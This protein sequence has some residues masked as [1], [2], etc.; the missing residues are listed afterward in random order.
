MA[1]QL[2]GPEAIRAARETWRRGQIVE[3]ATRLMEKQGFHQMSVAALADEAGISV[4]TIYQYVQRKEDVLL[5]VILDILDAYREEMPAVM[6]GIADPIERLAAGFRAYCGV[7]DRR[8]SATVLTYRESKAL[9]ED[10]LHKIMQLELETT[11][12][13]AACLREARAAGIVAD[14]DLDLTSDDLMM[15]AHMWAL[16][17][18]HLG[19]LSLDEYVDRQLGVMLRAII[20]PECQDSYRSLIGGSGNN[21][22]VLSARRKRDGASQRTRSDTR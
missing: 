1:K 15:V 13:L 6:A 21:R 19:Q 3:A 8:R 10:G 14:V 7:V 4:G 16:K 11:G 17:H 2:T 18:W 9:D 22:T 20:R 12:L 5:L